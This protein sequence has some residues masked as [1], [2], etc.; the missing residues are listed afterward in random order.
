MLSAKEEKFQCDMVLAS[1]EAFAEELDKVKQ[2]KNLRLF[3]EYLLLLK[4]GYLVGLQKN[5]SLPFVS[6]RNK[7]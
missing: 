3:F 6:Q 2:F 5:E 1:I 7:G 4:Q